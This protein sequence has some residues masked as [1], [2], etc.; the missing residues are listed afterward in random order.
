MSLTW[1]DAAATTLVG[2][3]GVIT[4]ARVKGFSWPLL[5]NW[6]MGSLALI[7]VGLAACIVIGSGAVPAKNT[8]TTTATVLGGLSFALAIVGLIT[9]SKVV[10][11]V[12]AADIAALWLLTTVHHVITEGV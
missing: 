1:K 3:G 2:V 4:Y 6:R 8:W 5:T 12:L 10:F 11:L 9:N 7:V